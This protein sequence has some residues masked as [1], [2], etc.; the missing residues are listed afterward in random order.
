MLGVRHDPHH[1]ILAQPRAQPVEEGNRGDGIGAG[2][3]PEI[4]AR[5]RRGLLA[6]ERDRDHRRRQH[7][8]RKPLAQHGNEMRGLARRRGQCEAHARFRRSG[9]QREMPFVRE[10]ERHR[11]DAAPASEQPAGELVDEP[12]HRERERLD[13]FHRGRQFQPARV[14]RRR[15]ERQPWIG[16][17]PLRAVERGDEIRADTA[18]ERVA[19]QRARRPEGRDAGGGERRERI[20]IEIE[21]REALRGERGSEN[22]VGYGLFRRSRDISRVRGKVV[23]DSLFAG[24]REQQRGRRRRG[25]GES[26]GVAEVVHAARD[27]RRQWRQAT[28]E[29]Q[30]A[31][32]LGQ[33]RIRQARGSRPA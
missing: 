32:D 5:Q 9:A 7:D 10:H 25:E 13:A 12:V 1:R 31:A 33:H 18:G 4:A 2:Q 14:A 30:A 6:R 29:T 21:M 27:M 23:P 20:G 3:E 11:D 17:E 22:G 28:E 24:T 15:H 16:D 26:R 19:R 8:P